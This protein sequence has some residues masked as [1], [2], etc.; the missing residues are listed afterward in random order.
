MA[1]KYPT[2]DDCKKKSPYIIDQI[3][4]GKRRKLC[5]KCAAEKGV[6]T[7]EIARQLQLPLTYGDDF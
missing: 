1:I 4:K 2:C 3:V 7:G 5:G 6:V